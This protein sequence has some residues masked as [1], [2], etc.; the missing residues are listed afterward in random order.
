MRGTERNAHRKDRSLVDDALSLD[1]AAMQLDQLVHEREPDAGA[2]MRA[3]TRVR[4]PIEAFEDMRKRVGGNA[5]AGV[6]DGQHG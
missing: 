1:H 3:P 4:H 6:G 2:L 5:N